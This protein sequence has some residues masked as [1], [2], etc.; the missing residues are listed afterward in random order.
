MW[1]LDAD[2]EYRGLWR[3]HNSEIC[4]SAIFLLWCQVLFTYQV[5][6]GFRW[7]NMHIMKRGEGAGGSGGWGSNISSEKQVVFFLREGTGASI[8]HGGHVGFISLFIS[9][10][11]QCVALPQ[12]T[13]LVLKL[14]NSRVTLS[15]L[16][17]AAV[18][19]HQGHI[20]SQLFLEYTP[21]AYS[22]LPSSCFVMVLHLYTFYKSNILL[23]TAL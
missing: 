17:L 11:F 23:C 9:L 2:G 22:R 14:T 8:S 15:G 5:L 20:S 10:V 1:I 3:L 6:V 16:M 19:M 4:A 7:H 18:P 21:P 13:W 12:V